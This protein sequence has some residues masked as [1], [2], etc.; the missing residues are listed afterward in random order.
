MIERLLAWF[1]TRGFHWRVTHLKGDCTW[2]YC[3][4]KCRDCDE[5]H[6]Q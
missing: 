3:T 6:L 1:C 4:Y 5:V 2:A